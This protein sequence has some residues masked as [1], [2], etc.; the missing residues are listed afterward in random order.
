MVWAASHNEARG[1]TGI[2]SHGATAGAIAEEAL[3]YMQ[4]RGIDPERAMLFLVRGFVSEILDSV[5]IE[6]LR[7][8]LEERTTQAL[9]RF[10]ELA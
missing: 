7:K 5:T 8:W 9:P 10:R 1:K 3:F 4:S 2:S 6:P